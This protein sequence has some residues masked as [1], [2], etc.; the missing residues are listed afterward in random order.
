MHV[1]QNRRWLGCVLGIGLIGAAPALGD[2]SS[3]VLRVATLNLAH[4]RGTAPSQFGLPVATYQKNIDAI[5]AAIRREKPDVLALQEADAPSSW[6]GSFDHVQVLAGSAEYAHVFHGLHFEAGVFYWKLQYG[7]ALLARCALDAPASYRFS[8]P[9]L[10][11]KGF[12]IA[13]LKFDGRPLIVTSVHLTSGSSAIRRKEAERI[14]SILTKFD[15]PIVLMGDFNSR[16]SHETDAVR[17]LATRLGLHAFHADEQG[18]ATFSVRVP[19]TRIDWILIP[20]D[21]EFIDYHVWEGEISDHFG[22]SADV[23][24]RDY[25]AP[26]SGAAGDGGAANRKAG[27]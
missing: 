26:D 25:T 3:H 16:W 19:K 24:W 13:E 12:V 27:H 11:T 5:A 9:P 17:I 21:L 1:Y 2:E 10:H 6:S 22:V 14:I 15:K 18:L 23:R 7:T 4:G 8:V 20:A